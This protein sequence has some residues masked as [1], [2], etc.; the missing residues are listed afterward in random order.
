[1]TSLAALRASFEQGLRDDQCASVVPADGLALLDVVEAAK[2]LRP[3]VIPITLNGVSSKHEIAA[4]DAALAK[5]GEL[6]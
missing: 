3:Y 2:A 4:F 5:L 1:M 6:K